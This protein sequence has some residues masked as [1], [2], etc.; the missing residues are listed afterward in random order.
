M[1]KKLLYLFLFIIISLFVFLNKINAI[2]VIE[3]EKK[4]V[5]I[6]EEFTCSITTGGV[7]TSITTPLTIVNGKK[8]MT[9]DGKITFKASTSG[10]YSISLKTEDG[11]EKQDA[12]KINVTDIT[13]KQSTT[14]T[15]TT[16]AKSSNTY[17]AYIKI[18]KENIKDFKKDKYEYEVLVKEDVDKAIFDAKAEDDKSNVSLDGNTSLKEGKNVFNIKVTA[19]DNSSKIYKVI[20]TKEKAKSKNSKIKSIKIKG[21]DF[22]FDGNSK[23]GYLKVK[24]NVDKLNITV[25]LD[26]LK[27]TYK[28]TGNESLKDGS[29]IK[30]NV[31]SENNDTST[32]RIIIEK[33]KDV[34]KSNNLIVIIIITAVLLGLI[35][36]FI[37]FKNK[38]KNISN[39]ENEDLD[40]TKTYY[41]LDDNS[42]EKVD[43]DDI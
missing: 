3:C 17:L 21:Y 37:I 26:D 30:I 31:I 43:N 16:N 42:D 8:E 40:K 25:V 18:N 32:Y 9:E 23:T 34:S 6:N 35:L 1:R 27:S 5:K 29:I 28:I 20:I 12:V 14:T 11:Y 38:N 7:K 4:E 33:N 41:N 15:T 10:S 39:K 36:F 2:A 24:E 22:S 19:E 13:T